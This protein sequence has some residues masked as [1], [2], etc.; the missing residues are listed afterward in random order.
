MN[1]IS[2]WRQNRAEASERARVVRL[3]S[4]YSAESSVIIEAI[5]PPHATFGVFFEDRAPGAVRVIFGLRALSVA[6]FGIQPNRLSLQFSVYFKGS[7]AARGEIT[8]LPLTS[9]FHFAGGSHMEPLEFKVPWTAGSAP[10]MREALL[11]EVFGSLRLLGPWQ[12]EYQTSKFNS[13]VYLTAR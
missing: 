4:T 3:A 6:P 5:D 9:D 10:N 13:S 8:D 7:V 1:L 12:V 11:V 2:R